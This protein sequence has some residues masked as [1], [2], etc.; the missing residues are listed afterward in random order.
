MCG[1]FDLEQFSRSRILVVGDVMLD[2]YL[3]GE[4]QRISPE[5]PVPVF[6]IK[7]KSEV[8]GGAGNVVSNL[9]GLGGSV[10]VIGVCGNDPR[11][12][13]LSR[14]LN[15]GRVE[16]HILVDPKRPT[17]TKTRAVS[18]GQQLLRLDEEEVAPIGEDIET[19][20]I[21]LVEATLPL[22]TAVILSDYGKGLLRGEKLPR[23]VIDFA[24][25]RRVP[26]IVDPKGKDW[27]R[28]QGATCVTPNV[29]ELEAVHGNAVADK[30]VLVQAM[31][32][33]LDKYDLTWLVVTRGPLGVCLMSRD[34]APIFVPA[35]AR[36]VYDLSGAGDTVI[37]TLGLAVGA[38]LTFPD[39]AKLANLAAGIVVAKVGTQPINLLE[40]QASL[41]TTGVDAMA[42]DSTRKLASLGAAIIQVDAW[43]ASGQK[44]VVTNGCFDLLHPGHIHLLTQ[45]KNL[46]D[47][48]V[49]AVN[50]DD[51][52][53]RLKGPRR[54]ILAERDRVSLLA[55]L[56]CVDLVLLF[57]ADTPE[58]LLKAL[59]P[60]VLVKGA[61]YKPEQV[62]GRQIVEAHGGQVQL[63][64][65]LTGYSTT[66]ITKRMLQAYQS[67]PP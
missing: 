24:K 32:S 36:Q 2:R 47:R 49:V 1:R 65:L 63:V 9:A 18:H 25:E 7:R 51:S 11:G 43:K 22:C 33:I 59:K 26:V 39:A 48:L 13:R 38:G 58:D 45:A 52:V 21:E 62:V 41:E 17:V 4:V 55:S 40:L 15:N 56:H 66:A 23:F 14:L 8:P 29:K 10:T 53:R 27:E 54:P 60:H 57:D 31:G 34:S 16:A 37:A 3:W 64:P 42:T 30:E 67:V 35:L 46:G 6:Q 20:I 61:D 12:E 19:S 5:A 28:Y 50:S 44:V